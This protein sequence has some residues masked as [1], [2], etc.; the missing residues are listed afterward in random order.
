MRKPKNNKKKNNNETNKKKTTK[1]IFLNFYNL[2]ITFYFFY[3]K[4]KK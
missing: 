4:L 2:K 1:I 3:Q